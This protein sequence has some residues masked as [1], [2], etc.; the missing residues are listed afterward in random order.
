MAD[1]SGLEV[2]YLNKEPGVFQQGMQVNMEMMIKIMKS[3]L[4]N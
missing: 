2:E 4:K 3:F 1:D